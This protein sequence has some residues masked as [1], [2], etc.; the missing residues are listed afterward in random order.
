VNPL[1]KLK[2]LEFISPTGAGIILICFFLPWMKVSCG[3]K[4]M[5][6]SGAG[7]GGIFWL[8][9]AS[10]LTML[11]LFIFLV[12]RVR[13]LF[14]RV[15][16][17][18]GSIVSAAVLFYKYATVASDPEIPFYLPQGMV[19]FELKTG[20]LGTILG[21]AMTTFGTLILG[22]KSVKSAGRADGTATPSGGKK[23]P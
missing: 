12:K 14:L 19:K 2:F 23:S 7:I 8:V 17:L 13:R 4:D 18:L 16:F 20:A 11:F 3:S 22:R 5:I 10:A 15:V 6:L 9:F 1:S 21:L